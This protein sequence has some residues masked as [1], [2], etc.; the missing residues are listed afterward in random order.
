MTERGRQRY[1]DH[2]TVEGIAHVRLNRPDKL[3]ALTLQTL[4][5]LVVTARALR[6]DRDLRAGRTTLVVTTSPAWLSRC[7]RVLFLDPGPDGGG[8]WRDG[9]HTDFLARNAAY[10]EAV[11]R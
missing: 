10:R 11:A 9:L 6:G 8:T 3:N 4:D 2:E 5:E 1:V 7:A